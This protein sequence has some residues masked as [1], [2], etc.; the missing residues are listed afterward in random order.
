MV[1]EVLIA[2]CGVSA[3]G[4][5]LE[6]GFI[7][8]TAQVAADRSDWSDRHTVVTKDFASGSGGIQRIRR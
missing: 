6:I 3:R 2:P 1:V 5:L 7:E 4:D 8:A